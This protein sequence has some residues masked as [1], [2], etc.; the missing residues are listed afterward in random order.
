MSPTER[1]R[2][3]AR[4]RRT[5]NTDAPWSRRAR[6]ELTQRLMTEYAGAL[7]PGQIVAAVARAGLVL[8]T[9]GLEDL[10]SRVAMWEGLAR[11]SV[12]ERVACAPR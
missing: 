10:A 1:S 7:P 3:L 11:R 4:P 2:T 12:V 9:A 5:S 8:R 6:D